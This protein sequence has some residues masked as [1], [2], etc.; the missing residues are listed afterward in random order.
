MVFGRTE[1][2]FWNMTFAQLMVLIQVH[3]EV[4]GLDGAGHQQ[5]ERRIDASDDRA[6]AVLAGLAAGRMA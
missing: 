6:A 4:N 2:D 1:A 3:R 5:G